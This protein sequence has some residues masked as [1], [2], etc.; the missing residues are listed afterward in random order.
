MNKRLKKVFEKAKNYIVKS[1]GFLTETGSLISYKEWHSFGIGALDGFM[2]PSKDY[3]GR[4]SK[5]RKENEDVDEEP[6][7]FKIGNLAAK[8]G[9]IVLGGIVLLLSALVSVYFLKQW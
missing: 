8:K 5:V 7:Y 6:H 4:L 9:Y 1:D 3:I 2:N